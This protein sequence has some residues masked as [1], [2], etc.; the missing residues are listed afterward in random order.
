VLPDFFRFALP[1]GAE[2]SHHGTSLALKSAAGHEH[3]ATHLDASGKDKSI[4]FATH[5]AGLQGRDILV[6]KTNAATIA[7]PHRWM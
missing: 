3:N 1:F 7:R 4:E 2:R 5:F 6:R